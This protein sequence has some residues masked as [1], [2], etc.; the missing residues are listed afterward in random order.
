MKN[1]GYPLLHIAICLFIGVSSVSA[2]DRI[3]DMQNNKL[4]FIPGKWVPSSTFVRKSTYCYREY[5]CKPADNVRF[6]RNVK[7]KSTKLQRRKSVCIG[8]AEN[9]Q[10]KTAPPTLACEVKFLKRR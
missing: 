4:K 3:A 9:C 6:G 7:I 8:P 5:I 2:A 1:Y 10:C